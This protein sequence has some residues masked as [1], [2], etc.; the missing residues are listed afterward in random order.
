MSLLFI[1]AFSAP[2]EANVEEPSKAKAE[3]K[4]DVEA[5]N[6]DIGYHGKGYYG[7]VGNGE[8]DPYGYR[9]VGNGD[10]DPYGYRNVDVKGNQVAKN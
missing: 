1:G 2:L 9:N 6:G 7:K 3:H 5:A 10:I 8:I 4:R